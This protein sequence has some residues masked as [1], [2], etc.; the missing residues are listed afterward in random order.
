MNIHEIYVGSDGEA[1]KALYAQL[2]AL[3]TVGVVAVKPVSRAEV[4]LAREG[5]P[6]PGLQAECLR[7]EELVNRQ[8][9]ASPH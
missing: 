4:Q 1:T 7:S 5:L 3:G 8:S 9:G 2:E 6:W